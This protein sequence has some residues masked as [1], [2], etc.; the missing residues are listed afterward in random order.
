MPFPALRQGPALLL[1]FR[2]RSLL[3]QTQSCAAQHRFFVFDTA[4]PSAVSNSTTNR[5]SAHAVANSG[6]ERRHAT[7]LVAYPNYFLDLKKEYLPV[8]D[9]PRSCGP[10]DG[11]HNSVYHLV[12]DYDFELDLGQELDAVFM[13]VIR[14]RM[15]LLPAVPTHF[16][17]RHPIYANI[18][19]SLLNVVKL[20]GLNHRFDFN[21]HRLLFSPYTQRL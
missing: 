21:H 4:R 1:H 11:L 17:S 10:C 16:R 20:G 12:L 9:F 14:L 18:N 6:L 19:Q 3:R 13:S 2:Q 8:A 5:I 15:D 7:F